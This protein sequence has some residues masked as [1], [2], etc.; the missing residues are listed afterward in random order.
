MAVMIRGAVL[1]AL[2]APVAQSQQQTTAT[3]S[4]GYHIVHPEKAAATQ[5]AP[6]GKARKAPTKTKKH[7]K[8]VVPGK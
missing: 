5:Q 6:A 2:L 4:D 8:S 7:L 3:V 1:L